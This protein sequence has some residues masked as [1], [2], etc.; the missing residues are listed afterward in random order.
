MKL[1]QNPVAAHEERRGDASIPGKPMVWILTKYRVTRFWDSFMTYC[2]FGKLSFVL[3]LLCGTPLLAQTPLGTS[4]TYQGR[5]KQAGVAV[6]GALPITFRLYDQSVGG[7]PLAS[8]FA[9]NVVIED[10]LFTTA[11]DFGVAAFTGDARWVEVVVDGEVLS[12]RQPITAVPYALKV[13]GVDDHSLNAADGAPTDAVYVDADGRVGVGTFAP[14]MSLE[15]RTPS[16]YGR[17]ALGVAHSDDYLYL[18]GASDHS[19]I[20]NQEAD[21]RFGTEQSPG[22]GYSERLRITADGRLGIGTDAPEFPLH[23][24]GSAKISDGNLH[25]VHATSSPFISLRN[26][27]PGGLDW[28]ITSTDES[29]SGGAG[30]FWISSPTVGN[31]FNVQPNGNVGIGTMTPQA[32]LDVAGETRTHVLRITGGADVA[33]PFDVGGAVIPRPGMLVSIDPRNV[34]KLTVSTTAYDRA[35]AGVISGANQINPGMVLAQ[36]GSAADGQ[37]PVA[38]TGRVYAWCDADAAG[39]IEPGDL[40]TSSDTPGHA[41]KAADAARAPGAT[42]GKA[43]SSL[44]HG[45]GLVLVLVSLQ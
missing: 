19:I 45:K 12:P 34:G 4:F 8:Y 2:V 18:H 37:H 20:W 1:S 42:I 32:K 39:P 29:A 35:V 22:A 11:V 9:G 3:V 41:M 25:V 44:K 14:G 7:T 26:S 30:Q 24:V 40:L 23:T 21:L 31:V 28:R 13:P 36:E 6:D 17:P 33:E 43:M 10:G 38:L 5:M 15:V 27:E 16:Y